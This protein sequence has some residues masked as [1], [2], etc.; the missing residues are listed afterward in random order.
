MRFGFLGK[1]KW[2][3]AENVS[4]FWAYAF[5]DNEPADKGSYSG[6]RAAPPP[7]TRAVSSY[8]TQTHS[9]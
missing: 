3:A 9:T 7:S 4:L 5:W 1:Q 8:G 6:N 2:R